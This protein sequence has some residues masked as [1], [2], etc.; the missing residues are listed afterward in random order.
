[1]HTAIKGSK[2]TIDKQ[3]EVLVNWQGY[4]EKRKFLVS[5]LDSTDVIMGAPALA[6][7]QAITYHKSG[8]V[9]IKPPKRERYELKMISDKED[10]SHIESYRISTKYTVM[11]YMSVSD[12]D[13][14]YNPL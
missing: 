8:N 9:S 5:N 10:M 2:S 13:Q 6:D 11:S 4:E 1:M 3:A 7:M 12:T 14:D